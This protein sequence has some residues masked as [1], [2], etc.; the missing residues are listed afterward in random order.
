MFTIRIKTKSTKKFSWNSSGG[1]SFGERT[2]PGLREA[3]VE[4]IEDFQDYVHGDGA[5]KGIQACL[6]TWED[7][8]ELHAFLFPQDSGIPTDL[9]W[10]LMQTQPDHVTREDK[11]P[12]RS[13]E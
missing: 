6:V 4:A 7:G 12:T 2:A 3:V 5:Q 8:E 1:R 11:L 9:P 10:T 13:M